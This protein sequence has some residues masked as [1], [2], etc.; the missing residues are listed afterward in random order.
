M[1]A[2]VVVAAVALSEYSTL[3]TSLLTARRS[4][5]RAEVVEAVLMMVALAER[6][7][8]AHLSSVR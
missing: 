7:R 3:E 8:T 1:A 4:L 6:A 5:Y 2:V